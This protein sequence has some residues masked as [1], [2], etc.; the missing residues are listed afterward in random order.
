[1]LTRRLMNHE[2]GGWA[3]LCILG[4]LVITVPVLNLAVPQDNPF[5]VP[6]STVTLMGKYLLPNL[7]RCNSNLAHAGHPSLPETLWTYTAARLYRTTAGCVK[8]M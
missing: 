4:V 1:M 7:P 6:T 5:H 2:W 8:Y 3:L